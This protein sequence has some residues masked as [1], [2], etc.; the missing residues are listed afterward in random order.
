MARNRKLT[1]GRTGPTQLRH[2]DRELVQQGLA[3]H[4]E[5]EQAQ[6]EQRHQRSTGMTAANWPHRD[7]VRS[8]PP[9]TRQAL[10]CDVCD[11][12]NERDERINNSIRRSLAG[13]RKEH[14]ERKLVA[15]GFTPEE[16]ALAQ[17]NSKRFFGFESDNEDW[18]KK[19]MVDRRRKDKQRAVVNEV[20][21]TKKASTN[22]SHA[23]TDAREKAE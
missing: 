19:V 7:R 16:I 20:V 18:L 10:H 3:K 4:R 13:L 8:S 23:W 21:H 9:K 12:S 17:A 6:Q 1:A 22:Y 15:A 14:T 5:M 11:G 2:T